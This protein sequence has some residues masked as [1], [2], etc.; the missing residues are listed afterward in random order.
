MYGLYIVDQES[1]SLIR[2]K[3]LE[4]KNI[5]AITTAGDYLW[6]IESMN[7]F[8]RIGKDHALESFPAQDFTTDELSC[9]L[10]ME[11]GTIYLMPARPT[12]LALAPFL[13]DCGENVGIDF[14]ECSHGFPP[15]TAQT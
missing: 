1:E 4:G 12:L 6:G 2:V 10:G 7:S 15:F 14:I 11:D 13:I 9:I 3:G 5:K 8:F